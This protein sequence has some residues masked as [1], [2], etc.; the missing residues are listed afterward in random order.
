MNIEYFTPLS[1]AWERMKKALFKPFDI[2]KWFAL[3]FTAFL[4]QLLD[5]CGH[6]TFSSNSGGGENIN[7]PDIGH[8]PERTTDWIHAHPFLVAAILTGILI[9]IAVILV[10]TWLSSRGA[11][12]FLDNVVHDRAL[13][14]KP[15]HEYRIQGN[16]LF[17]WRIGFGIVIT[18]LIL[19]SLAL[20]LIQI[21][22]YAH[23]PYTLLHILFFIMLGFFW[24]VASV[25][26][27]YISLFTHGFVVPV[28]YRHD[29]KILEAWRKFLPILKSHFIHFFLYGLLFLL[30]YICIAV[31]AVFAGCMTCCCGFILLAVPYIGSVVLL[32][33]S[34]T[35]RAFSLEFLAQW[36]PDY[37]VFPDEA[38]RSDDIPPPPTPPP[39]GVHVSGM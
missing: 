10:F 5:S 27:G 36:G 15:W 26:I 35:L 25:I 29:L 17:F 18:L 37:S 6:G 24:L 38:S 8:I 13:V 31:A 12:M 9:I 34:F 1:N 7:L 2:G 39:A 20:V 16:S 19:A 32:P 28:M 14:V 3:G 4:S 30:L 33:V 23:G 11:F 22:R 21:G